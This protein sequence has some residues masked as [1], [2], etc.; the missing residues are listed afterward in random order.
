MNEKLRAAEAARL[1]ALEWIR[2]GEVEGL[3]R[4]VEVAHGYAMGRTDFPG[5]AMHREM[6]AVIAGAIRALIPSDV[7]VRECGTKDIDESAMLS[8]REKP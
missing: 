2:L 4:A 8:Q 3:M 1:E 6:A 5:N 7:Q